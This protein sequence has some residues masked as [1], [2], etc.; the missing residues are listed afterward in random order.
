MYNSIY[1]YIYIVCCVLLSVVIY[2]YIYIGICVDKCVSEYIHM[3]ACICI[4]SSIYNPLSWGQRYDS[5]KAQYL[6][7]R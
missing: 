6:V 5:L 3:S 2:I 7:N 4:F 1:I